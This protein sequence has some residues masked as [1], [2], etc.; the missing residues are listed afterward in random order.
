[1]V[2]D[3]HVESNHRKHRR[4]FSPSDEVFKSPKRHKS[5]HHH[6]RHGHR[7]HRD[8]EVQYN[9]DENVNGGDLD[10][11]E[12]EILGK[13]GIGETLK[14]KLESVDEFVDIKSGQFRENNL[15]I[16]F[17]DGGIKRLLIESRESLDFSFV[18]CGFVPFIL[19]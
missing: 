9:D 5:R 14:K 2:S 15:L 16:F 6:R 17:S 12:G 8:E 3:K 1:M 4:S 7:H 13:E 18:I 19:L 11:E 10:M